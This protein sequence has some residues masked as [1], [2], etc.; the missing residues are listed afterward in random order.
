MNV[1]SKNLMRKFEFV[2][3]LNIHSNIYIFPHLSLHSPSEVAE[4]QHVTFFSFF[5]Y[6]QAFGIKITWYLPTLLK[7]GSTHLHK[8]FSL[9]RIWLL[10]ISHTL[11]MLI[12][13]NQFPT[14]WTGS[15]LLDVRAQ[16]R[17]TFIVKAHHNLK[18]ASA[19]SSSGKCLLETNIVE[20]PN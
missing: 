1:K 7:N 14:L 5:F 20:G 19:S 9:V 3:F 10:S 17:N 11:D 15:S 12:K 4:K 16:P 8:Q 18:H 13:P 2:D 6:W